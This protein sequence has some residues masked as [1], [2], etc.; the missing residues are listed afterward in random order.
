MSFV[1]KFDNISYNLDSDLIRLYQEVGN[2][3][4][5]I[6]IKTPYVALIGAILGQ[7]IKYTTAKQLRSN[8]YHKIG[9]NFSIKD[10]NNLSYEDMIDMNFSKRQIQTIINVNNYLITNNFK[11]NKENIEHL[12]IVDGIG[13]W[14]IKTTLLTSF[15]DLDI[16]PENDYFIQKRLQKLLGLAKKPSAKESLEISKRWKPFRTWVT[17]YLWR[18]F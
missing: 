10:I 18:W 7:R 8:L 14:T 9:T 13:T 3:D 6:L 1:L 5:N 17:W 2:L 4:W 15:L 12:I 16:F 11:L